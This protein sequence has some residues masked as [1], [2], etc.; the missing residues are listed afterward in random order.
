MG[1]IE[2]RREIWKDI[3]E[4]EAREKEKEATELQQKQAEDNIDL[5]ATENE[6]GLRSLQ[7]LCDT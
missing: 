7:K 4:K 2:Y 3:V 5:R 6:K 1:N